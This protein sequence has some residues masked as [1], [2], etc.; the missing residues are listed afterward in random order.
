MDANYYLSRNAWFVPHLLGN[1]HVCSFIVSQHFFSTVFRYIFYQETATFENTNSSN[2][3]TKESDECTTS[4]LKIS[5]TTVSRQWKC[6]NAF[7]HGQCKFVICETCCKEKKKEKDN[8]NCVLS[9]CTDRDKLN[10]SKTGKL[11]TSRR[12]PERPRGSRTSKKDDTGITAEDRKCGDHMGKNNEGRLKR[13][14]KI[15][16]D[17]L[18]PV[19]VSDADYWKQAFRSN[20]EKYPHIP[21]ECAVCELPFVNGKMSR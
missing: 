17:K 7:L 6:P 19:D 14:G 9:P 20:I 8:D 21:M 11:S 16:F 15:D 2:A 3:E 18:I 13:D 5:S 10:E 4:I 1:C 12:P